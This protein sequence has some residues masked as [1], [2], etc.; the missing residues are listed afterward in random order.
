MQDLED[1]IDAYRAHTLGLAALLDAVEARGAQPAT[2]HLAELDAL[3]RLSGAGDLEPA[4]ARALVRRLQTLQETDAREGGSDAPL[5]ADATKVKPRSPT[6]ADMDNAAAIAANDAATIVQP[7]FQRTPMADDATV[8]KPASRGRGGDSGGGTGTRGDA[9]TGTSGTSRSDSSRNQA[10]WRRVAEAE[11]GAY[12]TVGMLLKGRFLLE[13]ELG[14]GGMGVVYL[15]RDE[16]KVEARDRDPYVAIKVLNDEFRRHPD[17]LIALQR[18]ARRAQQLAHDN[19]VRVYDFDKDGTIVFMTMEY[20]DGIDMRTLIREQAFNGMSIDDAWPLIKGMG[21]ALERAH[22]N[23]I[24]HSD[25]KPGNVMVTRDGVPKVFDFGIARAGKY[26]GEAGG[27]AGGSGRQTGREAGFNELTIFDA[28]TLGALTPAYASLEMIEG[29]TPTPGDDVYAFGCVI[30]ELLTGQHP[31]DKLSAQAARAEGRKAP[32]VP[33]LTKR[34][35][36]ALAESLAF[37]GAERL[38]SVGTLLE[39][40][41]R[42]RLHERLAPYFAGAVVVALLA[43]GG[44]VLRNYTHERRAENVIARFS[45]GDSQHFANEDEAA[46]ALYG[47][48][49]EQRRHI[50]LDQGAAIE[51]FLLARLN[52]YWNPAAGLLNYA[53][54]QHVFQVRDRLELFSTALDARHRQIDDERRAALDDLNRQLDDAL[55]TDSSSEGRPARARE[56]IGRIRALDPASALLKS[57]Q[58]EQKI[59]ASALHSM[60]EDKFDEA[61][62]WLALGSQL[63]PDSAQLKERR[64]Q[65]AAAVAAVAAGLPVPIPGAMSVVDARHALADL[66]GHPAPGDDWQN[67]V[68]KAMA[69]LQNDASPE[70]KQAIDA[71]ADGIVV[72]IGRVSDPARSSQSLDLVRIGLKYDPQSTELLEQRDRLQSMLQQQQIDQQVDDDEVASRIDSVRRAAAANDAQSAQQSLDRIRALQPANS[73]LTGAGPQLVTNAYLGEARALCRQGKLA[74]AA[75]VA[76]QGAKALGAPVELSN[77]AERY[78]LAAA[79]A[80]ARSGHISEVDYEG[81]QA[82]YDAAQAADPDG[83]KQLD[84]DIKASQTLP[85]GG[86]RNWLAQV[87]AQVQAPLSGAQARRGAQS[88]IGGGRPRVRRARE[89]V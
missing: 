11:G 78:D 21:R 63:F 3:Q 76:A 47:L 19:I 73:F 27:E 44:W 34:Q 15:A 9:A 59:D 37:D 67:A 43:A 1:L 52:E 60:T 87:R 32:L 80:K 48:G 64:G 89:R 29:K 2:V 41:R 51:N 82:R 70:T 38:K 88:S 14:R 54:V 75:G 17:S 65:L 40:L 61:R 18:E 83:L 66:A 33:G 24:V 53:A 71:L 72:A 58:L 5:E 84:G 12:A 31:F 56:L 79:L 10:S 68:A 74:D 49:Q 13:R 39:G 45:M 81:L 16:R 85:G 4:V 25:F 22:A 23:G 69:V 55:D 28:G 35:N 26:G 8:V 50:V 46:Q 7:A 36:K 86:L 57:A 77:A 6:P 30:A 42:R 20:I 62:A